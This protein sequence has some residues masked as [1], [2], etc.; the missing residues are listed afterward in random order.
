MR[1][2][3][4]THDG[5]VFQYD[6][7]GDGEKHV[8]LQHGLSDYAPC[9]GRMILD[10][11]KKN[12]KITMMDARG[13]GRSGKPDNGYDLDTMTKD[14]MTFI[15]HLN[16]DHPVVIGHSMGAS[17]SIRAASSYP[18][19]LRAAVLIDPVFLDFTPEESDRNIN[20]RR[21]AYRKMRN[22]SHEEIRQLTQEKHPLWED[23]YVDPYVMSRVFT[24]PCEQIFDIQ[25]SIDKGWREDLRKAKCPL[26]LITAD[27]EK[28]AIIS[29]DTSN[30]IREMYPEIEILHVQKTGHNPHR[31]NYPLVIR[32]IS[33]FLEK[34]FNSQ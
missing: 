33:K 10:L 26:M 18:E 29:E 4:F 16:L 15:Q 23:I 12:Y 32:E 20:D 14:M 5:V 9:W 30:W 3:T 11:E 7:T 28:G 22:M 19:Q 21:L 31:E 25:S 6:L 27:Q 34:Q 17:M 2:G 13:H 1:S 8:V 24:I